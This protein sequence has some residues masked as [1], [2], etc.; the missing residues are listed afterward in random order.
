MTQFAESRS[1]QAAKSN[2]FI[3]LH[4]GRLR[5]ELFQRSSVLSKG[6][7]AFLLKA[8]ARNHGLPKNGA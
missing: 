6:S 1:P 8:I 4:R 5:S 3:D 2:D 7:T